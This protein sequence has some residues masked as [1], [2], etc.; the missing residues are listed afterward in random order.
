M[1]ETL[2]RRSMLPGRLVKK[3]LGGG[4]CWQDYVHTGHEGNLALESGDPSDY[5]VSMLEV[6]GTSATTEG[7]LRMEGRWQSKLQ[8][9]EMGFNRLYNGSSIR[10]A[11]PGIQLTHFKRYYV[12]TQTVL[13]LARDGGPTHSEWRCVRPGTANQ[14]IQAMREEGGE[15]LAV[16]PWPCAPDAGV[17]LCFGKRWFD[18]L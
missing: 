4:R 14:C 6:A 13:R 15:V 18:R 10:S 5:Q 2:P 16:T 11:A 1:R 9:R 12:R 7:I 17:V 8:S 3:D